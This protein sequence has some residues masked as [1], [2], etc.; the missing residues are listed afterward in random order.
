MAAA[1]SALSESNVGAMAPA[2][3]ADGQRVRTFRDQD[4]PSQR[5]KA[6]HESGPLESDQPGGPG[7][8]RARAVTVTVTVS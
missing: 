3:A 8:D 1:D 6:R 7:P 2:A 4:D 5:L